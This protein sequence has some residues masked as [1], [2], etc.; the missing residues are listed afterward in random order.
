VKRNTEAT[1]TEKTICMNDNL[2][3]NKKKQLGGAVELPGLGARA[4]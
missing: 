2:K 3:K 1:G 4:R